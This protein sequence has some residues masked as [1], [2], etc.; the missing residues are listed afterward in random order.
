MGEH[1]GLDCIYYFMKKLIKSV[2]LGTNV[3]DRY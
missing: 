2:K 3:S 1:K